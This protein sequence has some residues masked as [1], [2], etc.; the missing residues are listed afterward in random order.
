[1]A[2]GAQCRPDGAEVCTDQFGAVDGVSFGARGGA[3]VS[4]LG[5][6]NGCRYV[7]L[8]IPPPEAPAG[9]PSAT[10]YLGRLSV[11][12]VVA[13]LGCA[14]R[15][16]VGAGSRHSL[17]SCPRRPAGAAV[18]VGRPL[19]S[20]RQWTQGWQ[21]LVP[22]QGYHRATAVLPLAQLATIAHA[23]PS[24]RYATFL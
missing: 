24:L 14:R 7:W 9:N 1:M 15:E 13:A 5:I 6:Q 21:Y 10:T 23:V 11:A 19:R 18:I 3:R 20:E 8:L 4:R 22:R 12:P 2:L 16:L 17:A